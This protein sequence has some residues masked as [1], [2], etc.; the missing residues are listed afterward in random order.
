MAI[1]ILFVSLT[2]YLLQQC[3]HQYQVQEAIYKDNA[4]FVHQIPVSCFPCFQTLDLTLLNQK[5]HYNYCIL[6]EIVNSIKITVTANIDRI[7]FI[8]F[9]L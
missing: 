9:F 4:I 3:L 2:T 1:Q 5:I 6:Y 8:A 7:V